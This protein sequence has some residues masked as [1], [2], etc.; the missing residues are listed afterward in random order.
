MTA[1][2]LQN[3]AALERSETVANNRMNR[4]R[5]LYGNNSYTKD[6][7]IDPLRFLSDRLASQER[8]SWLDLCCG[9]GRALIEAGLVLQGQE[10]DG[11]FSLHGVDLIP[12][13]APLPPTLPCV[14]L[15]ETSLAT[16]RPDA[17]YDL[18]T[19]VHGLHYIGDKLGLIQRAITW[20]KPDG[21]FVAIS[22]TPTCGWTMA[23]RRPLSLAGRCDMR[24]WSIG[25]TSA[26]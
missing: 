26:S 20:L 14:H 16:W 15:E 3:D 1:Y 13:F 9:S 5:G 23:G 21:L 19:C 6:L 17:E 22:T 24:A 7:G 2:R 10:W 11:R 25:T 18:I 4:E 12:M 8:I